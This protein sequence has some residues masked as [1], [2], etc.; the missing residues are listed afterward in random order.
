MFYELLNNHLTDDLRDSFACLPEQLRDALEVQLAARLNTSSRVELADGEINFW[1]DSK[2]SVLASSLA[3]LKEVEVTVKPSL[4]DRLIRFCDK[5]NRNLLFYAVEMG[6]LEIVKHLVSLGSDVMVKEKGTEYTP[7]H[8]AVAARN[9]ELTKYLVHKAGADVNA[10]DAAG[11]IPLAYMS[12]RRIVA[13]LIMTGSELTQRNKG[14]TSPLWR[15]T[16]RNYGVVLD[17]AL[18]S[19]F[20]RLLAHVE[21]RQLPSGG[22]SS[23]SD[24][25]DEGYASSPHASDGEERKEGSPLAVRDG[26]E[27]KEAE[28]DDDDE[29]LKIRKEPSAPTIKQNINVPEDVEALE[30]EERRVWNDVLKQV[31]STKPFPAIGSADI[32]WSGEKMRNFL[33]HRDGSGYTLA[34]WAVYSGSEYG[35]QL[36]LSME[37]A[38]ALVRDNW[39]EMP[40]HLAARYNRPLIFHKMLHEVMGDLNVLND[41]GETPLHLCA[42]TL[43]PMVMAFYLEHGADVCALD[44][45]KKSPFWA[46][47]NRNFA[48]GV[49]NVAAAFYQYILNRLPWLREP[50]FS[51]TQT[52]E[53]LPSRRYLLGYPMTHMVNGSEVKRITGG[54]SNVFLYCYAA[55][56]ARLDPLLFFVGDTG[57]VESIKLRRKEQLAKFLGR[58][59]N[60]QADPSIPSPLTLEDISE[61]QLYTGCMSQ[62]P[63][64]GTERRSLKELQP[65]MKRPSKVS[66]VLN[67]LGGLNPQP[68]AKVVTHQ[69][70]STNYQTLLHIAS[71]YNYLEGMRALINMGSGV[72][73]KDG[74]GK[75][76]L[77]HAAALGLSDACKVL[78]NH[79][80]NVNAV[81]LTNETALFLASTSHGANTFGV[82]LSYGADFTWRSDSQRTALWSGTNRDFAWRIDYI[83]VPAYQLMLNRLEGAYVTPE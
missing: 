51:A 49:E 79:G 47:T 42:H 73:V 57:S 30:K 62:D 61:I 8:M 48:L 28:D 1:T 53:A 37:P 68:K 33:F 11:N 82:L 27:T 70:P 66:Q 44:F 7:L 24:Y 12:D 14:G 50:M 52:P 6:K 54:A 40:L 71:I 65:L 59:L 3:D 4:F 5:R 22:Q 75:T 46:T 9:Y 55:S 63:L 78:L 29:D 15:S 45:A 20:K 19:V 69:D 31:K 18:Q 74:E 35:L 76:P 72:D 26:M 34:H 36:L 25:D 13:L 56:G 17:E 67:K 83:L 2:Q 39:G 43:D 16:N 58:L 64:N 77:H 38:L 23:F 81:T 10:R 41:R 60:A 80:A 21:V 32:A